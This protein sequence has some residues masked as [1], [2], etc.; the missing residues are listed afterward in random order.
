MTGTPSPATAEKGQLWF[1]WMVEDLSA[2]IVR[3]MTETPPL[4]HSYFEV[5]S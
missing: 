1:E 2:L 5:A 3:G 4:E